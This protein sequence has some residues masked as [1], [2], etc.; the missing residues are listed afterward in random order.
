[1]PLSAARPLPDE[2]PASVLGLR[3]HG[4]RAIPAWLL[5]VVTHL[6]LALLLA[7][8]VRIAPRGAAVEP[9]RAAGIVL[10]QKHLGQREY[11]QEPGDSAVETASDTLDAAPHS[12]ADALP[13]AERP[14]VDLSG[15]FAAGEES[16]SATGV[17]LSDALPGADGLTTGAVRNRDFGG[18]AQTR[19]FGVQGQGTK[20]VYVFDRSSS[21]EGF[22]GRPLAAAKQ[23]LI[24]SLGDL[25]DVHQFQIIFYN[26]R[27]TVCNTTPG[28]TPRLLYGNERDRAAAT[29][30]VRNMSGAGGTRHFEPL[31]MALRMAPDVIFF[32]TD[33]DEPTLSQEELEKIRHANRR[34]GAS[35]NTVEFGIGPS[36]GEDNFLVKLARQNSGNHAYVDV[37]R[38]AAKR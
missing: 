19:V 25:G 26:D 13:A 6:A 33:A 21:M 7:F 37:A 3:M 12:A 30:F 23:E 11:F 31:M 34:Y 17:S 32:L 29:E 22:G 5:S 8:T 35:I 20:F 4:R 1:M 2:A 18:G 10:V 28:R 9:D 27:T 36:T 16:P 24:A 38:L 14:P 15:L